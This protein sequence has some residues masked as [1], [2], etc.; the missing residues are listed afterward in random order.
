M[1][2]VIP[3]FGRG[4]ISPAAYAQPNQ[5]VMLEMQGIMAALTPTQRG[6]MQQS[7]D[8]V[9]AQVAILEEHP[10]AAELMQDIQEC[11]TALHKRKMFELTTP[12]NL[13]A[14][15]DIT[16]Q[17]FTHSKVLDYFMRGVTN[18]Q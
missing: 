1:S 12:E 6:D 16:K 5:K 15:D 17:F 18:G 2:N 3:L 8:A 14:W 10:S 13:L 11:L 4:D 7:L 9:Q